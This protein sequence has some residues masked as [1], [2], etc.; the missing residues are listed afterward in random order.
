MNVNES[1]IFQALYLTWYITS[2][3]RDIRK[4]Q[5][6]SFFDFSFGIFFFKKSLLVCILWFLRTWAPCRLFRGIYFDS[7]AAG[8]GWAAQISR[9]GGLTVMRET[10]YSYSVFIDILNLGASFAGIIYEANAYHKDGDRPPQSP[11]AVSYN[12][13]EKQHAHGRCIGL[14]PFK[15]RHRQTRNSFFAAPPARRAKLNIYKTDSFF[16]AGIC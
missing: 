9:F 5:P 3:T 6:S 15:K 12:F 8:G 14:G 7:C 10:S 11:G 16:E 2:R 4:T 13:F 1:Q